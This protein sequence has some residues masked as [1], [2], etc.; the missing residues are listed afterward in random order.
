V[1]VVDAGKLA[2]HARDFDVLLGAQ[3]GKA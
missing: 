1:A 3:R 2:A